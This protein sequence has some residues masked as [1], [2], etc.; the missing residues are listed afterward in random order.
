M[1]SL[2]S[3]SIAAAA[4][5]LSLIFLLSGCARVT[6]IKKILDDPRDFSGKT[7]TIDGTVTEVT[8]LLF[9]K[10]FVVK[11]K[12]GEITVITNRPLPKEGAEISV[13]GSVRE[14]FALGDKDVIVIV[15]GEPQ[16]PN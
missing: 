1:N 11:D 16:K 15:E 2:R 7:V 9:F 8:G 6:P 3:R 12:T 5:L 4:S 13:T 10:Y 14:A